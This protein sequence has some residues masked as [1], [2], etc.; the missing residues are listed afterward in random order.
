MAQQIVYVN[1]ASRYNHDIKIICLQNVSFYPLLRLLVPS[2][3]IERP[4]DGIKTKTMGKLFVRILA[5]DPNGEIAKRLTLRS[6]D[7]SGKRDYADIVYEIMKNRAVSIGTLTIFD[8]NQRLD[9][10]SACYQ[11]NNRASKL[12]IFLHRIFDFFNGNFFQKSKMN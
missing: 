5:I 2:Y 4:A 1:S 6:A 9:N 10:I 11:S 8:V 7:G 12:I 3:D